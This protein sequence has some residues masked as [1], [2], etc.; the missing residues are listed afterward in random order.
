MHNLESLKENLNSFFSAVHAQMSK[1]FADS[2]PIVTYFFDE[3][4]YKLVIF[5]QQEKYFN[6]LMASKFN[7][8]DYIRPDENKI[9]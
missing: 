9:V 3:L 7:V 6:R 5:R 1:A 8:F 4:T 2:A